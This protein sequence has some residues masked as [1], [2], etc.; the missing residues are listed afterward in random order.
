MN[1]SFSESIS[2]FWTI[3]TKFELDRITFA[4][5]I[6]KNFLYTKKK[7]LQFS[8]Y[9]DKN[10]RVLR[11]DEKNLGRIGQFFIKFYFRFKIFFFMFF[12]SLR[13]IALISGYSEWYQYGIEMLVQRCFFA[14]GSRVYLFYYISPIFSYH[15]LFS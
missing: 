9:V 6:L 13:V 10:H 15:F 14:P 8:K 4:N 3:L 12:S 1:E 2:K 11:I 5:Q 7:T